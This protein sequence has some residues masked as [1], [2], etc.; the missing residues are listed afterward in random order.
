MIL[1]GPILW[2]FLNYYASNDYKALAINIPFALLSTI[3]LTVSWTNFLR[4]RDCSVKNILIGIGKLLLCSISFILIITATICIFMFFAYMT[5]FLFIPK[6]YLCYIISPGVFVA[7]IFFLL[8]LTCVYLLIGNFFSHKKGERTVDKYKPLFKKLWN[9]IIS[10]NLVAVY[11]I[12]TSLLI[13]SSEKIIDRSFLNPLG[14]VYT[15]SDIDNIHI[16]TDEDELIYAIN[17]TDGK[18]YNLADM[19][20]M[21]GMADSDNGYSYLVQIDEIAM[22]A[23]ASKVVSNVDIN[24]SDYDETSIK[25]I[26]KIINNK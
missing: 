2:L 5:E 12:P 19:D 11:L 1:L 8:E 4:K 21:G 10:L 6:D 26:E 3:I 20:N 13:A 22:N 17:M 23:G 7:C 18:T 25:N 16:S 15:Y 9:V 14:K 24:K